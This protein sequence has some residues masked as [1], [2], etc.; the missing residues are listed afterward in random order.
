MQRR[1]SFADLVGRDLP[2]QPARSVRKYQASGN[3]YVILDPADWPAPPRPE[4]VRRICDRHRGLGAD[5][6]LW[7]PRTPVEPFALR[8]FNP[9]GS[10]FE[11][12]GNGLSIFARYLWDRGLPTGPDFVLDTAGGP[13]TAHVPD[14]SGSTI[15]LELG[16]I[17]FPRLRAPDVASG[18][19]PGSSPGAEPKEMLREPVAVGG[20]RI[21]I[22]AVSIGNPHCVVFVD[23][24]PAGGGQDPACELGPALERLPLFPERTNVQ[25][26]RVVDR[27]TLAVTIWERG[28]GSTLAS[29]TSACAA[30]AAAIR[31]GQCDSPVTVVM[32]GGSLEVRITDDWAARITCPVEPVFAGELSPFFEQS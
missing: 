12:S 10:E 32:P 20:L 24:L 23:D 26:V 13:V 28:A 31:L 25:F 30:A 27:R 18:G 16:R 9:D 4:L 1:E 2:L 8:M 29:G 6:V 21:P 15:G 7:G 17:A 3:D 5:G 19:G 22:T 11:V 14:A